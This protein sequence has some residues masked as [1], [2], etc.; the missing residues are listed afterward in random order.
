V[1]A[2]ELIQVGAADLP[3]GDPR[4]VGRAEHRSESL[5]PSGAWR[6]QHLDRASRPDRLSDGPP[7]RD[8]LIAR[9]NHGGPSAHVTTATARQPI[10]S[11]A[12]P[13]PSGRVAF[14]EIRSI[15]IARISASRDR[16]S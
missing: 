12:S 10:P 11:P 3:D 15:G 2:R 1:I 13:K 4:A 14:T 16:I 5:V 6:H 9:S 7:P 8:Q